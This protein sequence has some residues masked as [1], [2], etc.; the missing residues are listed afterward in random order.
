MICERCFK[1]T[2]GHTM[3][4]FNTQTI[5]FACKDAEKLLPTYEEARRAEME[6]VQNGNY[7]FPGIGLPR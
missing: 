7:N 1:E 5:C 3:S 2:N 6:A 4:I